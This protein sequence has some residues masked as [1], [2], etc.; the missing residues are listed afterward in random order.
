MQRY[1]LTLWLWICGVMAVLGNP[2]DNLL[3][4]I[5]PGA[6]KKFKTELVKSERDFFELDQSGKKVVVRGNT[7][8]NIASG[9]N[10]YLKYYAGVHLTWNQMNAKLPAVLPK[11]EKKER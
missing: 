8:V 1:Y 2:V 5:D 11:V 10:W 7:W 3:N 6:A 9:V 4:R